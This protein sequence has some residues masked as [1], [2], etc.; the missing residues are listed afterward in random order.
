MSDRNLIESI[1]NEDVAS[2]EE[3][4]DA[5]LRAKI[6]EALFGDESE[7]EI[8]ESEQIDELSRKTLSNYVVKS[9]AD[10][11]KHITSYNDASKK[12]FRTLRPDQ[13]KQDHDYGETDDR[14]QERKDNVVR[15]RQKMAAQM[16]A[17]EPKIKNRTK[18]LARA[19]ARLAKEDVEQ[20]DELTGKGKLGQLT[21]Y[22]AQKSKDFAIKSKIASNRFDKTGK[23]DDDMDAR[24]HDADSRM[25]DLK[26][27]RAAALDKR[28]D[29]MASL[30]HAK[31]VNATYKKK[32]KDEDY[33]D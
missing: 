29:A 30:R 9:V 32:L 15:R 26:A 25:H 3:R 14:F 1:V 17:A 10:R 18:G 33:L 24:E 22:H 12:H 7:E 4:I 13:L 8:E 11:H 19:G 20:I 2:L 5:I 6:D 31:K 16:D 21:R 23:Y 27:G 28:A